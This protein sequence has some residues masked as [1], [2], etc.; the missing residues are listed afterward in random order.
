MYTFCGIVATAVSYGTCTPRQIA[1]LINAPIEDVEFALVHLT[2]IKYVI[3][4]MAKFN[5][6]VKTS[7]FRQILKKDC[8]ASKKF[9]RCKLRK[10]LSSYRTQKPTVE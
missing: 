9:R 10:K 3:K 6:F 4:P 8:R 7:T 2:N 5:L 1:Q